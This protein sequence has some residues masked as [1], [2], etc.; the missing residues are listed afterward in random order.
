MENDVELN[1]DDIG[2]LDLNESKKDKDLRDKKK[3]MNWKR[4]MNYSMKKDWNNVDM[5]LFLEIGLTQ[6]IIAFALI[7]ATRKSVLHCDRN[8]LYGEKD[9]VFSLGATI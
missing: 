8:D 1:T 3:A 4:K 7:R 9:Y 2:K 6:T 5:M